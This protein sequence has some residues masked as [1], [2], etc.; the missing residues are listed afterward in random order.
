MVDICVVAVLVVVF[1]SQ[2][3]IQLHLIMF[4]LDVNHHSVQFARPPHG[5]KY[6]HSQGG[7]GQI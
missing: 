4:V 7:K 1:G 2:L 5:R 3:T 6:E